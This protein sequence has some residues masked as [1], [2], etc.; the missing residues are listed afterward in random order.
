MGDDLDAEKRERGLEVN[1]H[2]CRAMVMT[3]LQ[4]Y[5]DIRVDGTKAFPNALVDRLQ[6]L[7]TV[8]LGRRVDANAFRCSDRRRRRPRPSPRRWSRWSSCRCPTSGPGVR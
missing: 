5:S 7:E 4:T 6:G 3:Y 1:G 2:V 8:T